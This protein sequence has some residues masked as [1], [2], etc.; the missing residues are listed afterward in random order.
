MNET[1][2]LLDI[3]RWHDTC[4]CSEWY[5][6]NYH[7]LSGISLNSFSGMS[8]WFGA[9]REVGFQTILSFGFT[10]DGWSSQDDFQISNISRDIFFNK[11][12]KHWWLRVSKFH[13]INS[14]SNPGWVFMK[15]VP[16]DETSRVCRVDILQLE[17]TFYV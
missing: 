1:F 8:K 5:N 16:I 17:L 10:W 6:H 13:L 9:N 15:Y 2:S 14:K 11:S 12:N 4:N 3:L 7:R